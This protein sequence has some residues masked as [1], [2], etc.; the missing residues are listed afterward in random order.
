MGGFTRHKRSWSNASCC[1]SARDI[2]DFD[3]LLWPSVFL[4]RIYKGS[5][6]ILKFGMYF[7]KYPIIPTSVL[8][9]PKVFSF[10]LTRT[11]TILMLFASNL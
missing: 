6:V 11:L 5:A 7:L 9:S 4:R 3:E 10:F 2:R 8:T 1:V